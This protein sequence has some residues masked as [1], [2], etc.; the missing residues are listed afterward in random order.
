MIYIV[1]ESTN[2]SRCIADPEPIQVYC[3]ITLLNITLHCQNSP[4][5]L[6]RK[7]L[8]TVYPMLFK[9]KL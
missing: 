3:K 5:N 4:F 2:E 6:Y 9:P 8:I 7:K 1:L